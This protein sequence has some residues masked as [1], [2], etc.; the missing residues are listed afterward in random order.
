MK[1]VLKATIQAQLEGIHNPPAAEGEPPFPAEHAGTLEL[2]LPGLD[3]KAAFELKIELME[4]IAVMVR[5]AGNADAPFVNILPITK[6]EGTPKIKAL[7]IIYSR[8]LDSLEHAWEEAVE[9]ENFYRPLEIYEEWE[10][11]DEARSLIEPAFQ[12]STIQ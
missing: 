11:L 7:L 12:P 6:E 3:K 5:D 9:E 4:E 2:A 1:L 8:F 10:L